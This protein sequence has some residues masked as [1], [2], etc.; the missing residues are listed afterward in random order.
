[1]KIVERY[2]KKRGNI[3]IK[4]GN[5]STK[6]LTSMNSKSLSC[7]ER[8]IPDLLPY[9]G[10][11]LSQELSTTVDAFVAVWRTELV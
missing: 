4:L 6:Y 8:N 7:N 1:M 10:G 2:S 9:F 3:N 11:V 5:T